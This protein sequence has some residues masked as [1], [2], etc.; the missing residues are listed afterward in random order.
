METGKACNIKEYSDMSSTTSLILESPKLQ[1]IQNPFCLRRGVEGKN[2]EFLTPYEAL[3]M[4]NGTVSRSFKL[5]YPVRF[6]QIQVLCCQS[7]H[8]YLQQTAVNQQLLSSQNWAEP[9]PTW[10]SAILKRSILDYLGPEIEISPTCLQQQLQRWLEIRQVTLKMRRE[11]TD[12]GLPMEFNKIHS[13]TA[14]H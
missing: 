3:E 7:K 6:Y 5:M 9:C 1:Q 11:N 2:E 13:Y 14:K 10:T 12:L 4:Q 8:P